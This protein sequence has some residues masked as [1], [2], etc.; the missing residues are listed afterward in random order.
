MVKEFFFIPHKKKVILYAPL[1]GIIALINS[2]AASEFKKKIKKGNLI[3]TKNELIKV[4]RPTPK[5]KD[6]FKNITFILTSDCTM[7]CIYC[8]AN[9]GESRKILSWDTFE[10]TLQYI[11]GNPQYIENHQLNISFHGGDITVVWPFFKK[12]V[13]HIYKTCADNGI[14]TN[15]S[16]GL[17]GVL[18]NVQIDWIIKNINSATISLD[19]F[20]EIQNRQRPLKNKK[21][22]F[23]KIDNT[24]RQ[25]DKSNFN[26][27]IR[28]TITKES[29]NKLDQ[30]VDFF[31]SSY[32][33]KKIM[34]EP[35][36]PMGRGEAILQP[37]AKNFV[38]NFRKAKGVAKKYNR[39]LYYSGARMNTTTNIF[40]KALE[41]SIVI[42][43]DGLISCC[44]EVLTESNPLSEY[45]F[46]GHYNNEKNEL[47]FNKEKRQKLFDLAV[48]NKKKCRD[49]FCL[50]HCAGDCPVK[51]IYTGLNNKVPVIDRCYINRA[52]TKDQILESIGEE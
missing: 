44:Y 26:Y 48:I 19:G 31:C 18:S 52:L 49:C 50:F 15:I 16:V 32:K 38:F 41:N 22:S 23:N 7:Q 45:F 25:F 42:T 46:F 35:I 27:G 21:D 24:L 33:V 20:A 51:S 11:I 13:T 10:G 40:C 28:S 12:A 4:E 43:P 1:H 8:Y 3:T 36:F 2:S 37:S 29:V 9:G 6:Y 39:E 17:N 30:I 47:I 14:K 34:V 5:E